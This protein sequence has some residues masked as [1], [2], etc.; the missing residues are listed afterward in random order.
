MRGGGQQPSASRI[1]RQQAPFSVRKI[2]NYDTFVLM[3]GKKMLKINT[4]MPETSDAF[5]L[6][7]RIKIKIFGDS[8]VNQGWISKILPLPELDNSLVLFLKKVKTVCKK[9]LFPFLS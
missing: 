2:Q 9:F 5:A 8:F 6:E 3:P 1:L 7:G 4:N